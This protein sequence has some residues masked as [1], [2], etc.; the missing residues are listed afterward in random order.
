[1][2]ITPDTKDWTW[3]LDRPCPECGFNTS[4][5]QREQVG[6]LLQANAAQWS[7]VLASADVAVRP[8]PEVW[9]SLEYGCHVRDVFRL[10]A[11]RLDLMLSED[12]PLFANWDQD[13]TAV[14]ERYG[15]QDPALVSV[16]LGEAAAE[17]AAA[18]DAVPPEQ[19]ERTGRRSDG[20][21]FTVETFAATSS[22][23]RS[24]ISTTPAVRPRLQEAVLR[25][26]TPEHLRIPRQRR[27]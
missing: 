18:F 24:T 21:N 20:A 26:W 25:R 10:Y 2:T 12:D 15:E 7:S 5:F 17:L 1:M 11:I 16:E 3:V 4:S 22:T 23:T 6:S 14:A 8:R 19:W 13:S 9:S 27:I